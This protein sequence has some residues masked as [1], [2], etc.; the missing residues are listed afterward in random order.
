MLLFI[1]EI[2]NN[3]TIALYIILSHIRMKFKYKYVKKGYAVAKDGKAK[4][5]LL[6]FYFLLF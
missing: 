5:L 2:K 6:C 1:H 4:Y 3:T